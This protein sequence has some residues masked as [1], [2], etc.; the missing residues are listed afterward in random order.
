[1]EGVDQFQF[2]IHTRSHD[3]QS[4][5]GKSKVHRLDILYF[6]G[7]CI[8][9]FGVV[10]HHSWILEGIFGCVFHKLTVCVDEFVEVGS[11]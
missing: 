10:P 2:L 3:I 5:D 4:T 9:G 1:M 8:V 11:R 7:T 6:P